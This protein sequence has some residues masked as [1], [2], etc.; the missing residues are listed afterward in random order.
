MGNTFELGTSQQIF[1]FR[2]VDKFYF[3]EVTQDDADGYVT[4]T[5]VHIPVQEIG[6]STDSASEAHYYDNKAMIVVNSESADT[7]TLTIAP[8]SL[9]KLA[10]L[11]GKSFD[12]TT[13]MLVDSP[14]QNKYYAI[15]YRTKGTDGGYRYVSRLK[16]QFNIPE[17]TFQT[18]N[19]GTD[20]NN[21]QITFTGIYTEHEFA[22]GV[23]DGS[24]WSPAG[25]KGIVVDARYGLADVSN[26]FDAIQTPDSIQVAPEPTGDIPVT[27]VSVT[28]TAG[29]VTVAQ[30]LTLTASVAPADATNKA[31]TW[32]SS[33]DSIA[34]VSDEGVVTGVAEG[35]AT[36]TVTTEDGGF[37]ATCN[38][39][40]EAATVAVTG[41]TVSPTSDSIT[42]GETL[43]LTATVA[44]ENATNKAVTWST[45]E[46]TVA[47]VEDGV[48]TGVSAGNATITVTTE[49]G[50]FTATCDVTVTS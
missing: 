47:T 16:G 49:D 40:V 48:V 4:G 14:R 12:A 2:G 9:D 3:A 46:A 25:V 22:K 23:Y 29:S 41:V 1:E 27:G 18:E 13:G 6:K 10:Q 32:S 37:T 17:E 50:G 8:P 11:I 43:T 30:T 36:I 45:S 33:S 24:N 20:T 28:P 44:P 19:D 21:T 35:D 42:V 26:F 39:T 5:P 38:V 34:T 15:M 7:I 31:V